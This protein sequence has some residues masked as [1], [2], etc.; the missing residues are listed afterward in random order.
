MRIV[1]NK[2]IH[3]FSISHIKLVNIKHSLS[4]ILKILGIQTQFQDNDVEIFEVDF[5]SIHYNK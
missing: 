1:D 4:L 3:S 5:Q 2:T